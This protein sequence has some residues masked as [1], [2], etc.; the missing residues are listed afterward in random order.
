MSHAIVR[1]DKVDKNRQ[2]RFY[3]LY[4]KFVGE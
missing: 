3:K 4:N 1:T 2:K